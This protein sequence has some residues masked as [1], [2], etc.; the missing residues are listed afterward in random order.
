MNNIFNVPSPVKIINNNNYPLSNDSILITN[1]EKV[2]L[3]LN[4]VK[5][6]I[7]STSK[8]QSKLIKNLNWIIK[9]ITSHS[10][11]AYELK[12]KQLLTKLNK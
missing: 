8:L 1:Y 11:Y 4:E 12:E 3:I 6:Y 10:L 5:N 9:V 7:N 2:L